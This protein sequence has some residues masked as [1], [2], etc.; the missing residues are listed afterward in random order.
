MKKAAL[1]LSA[2][3]LSAS[4]AAAADDPVASRKALMDANGAAAGLAAA[5]LKGDMDY[6]PAVAKAAIMTFRAVAHSYGAF[7]PEGSDKGETKASPKIWQDAAGF[8][9]ELAEFQ[10][11]ADAAAQASG[12][13]GPA[14]LNAFKAAVMPVFDDCKDCHQSYRVK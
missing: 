11:H 1:A 7:F 14:D 10:E 8:R 2:L 9:K 13:N 3:T 4:F 12:K 6:N 5:M